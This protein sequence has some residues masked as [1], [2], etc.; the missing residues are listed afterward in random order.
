MART[1]RKRPSR[2][3]P[4][5]NQGERTKS[6]ALGKSGGKDQKRGRLIAWTLV[7]LFAVFT[8]MKVRTYMNAQGLYEPYGLG[9]YPLFNERV[10]DLI[11]PR[12]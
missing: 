3:S 12:R 8:E 11:E 9:D 1:I 10:F 7:F 2:K 4:S 6:R 5:L